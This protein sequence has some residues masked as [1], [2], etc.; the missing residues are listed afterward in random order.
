MSPRVVV[1]DAPE[2]MAEHP[3]RLQRNQEIVNVGEPVQVPVDAVSVDPAVFPPRT[4]GRPVLVG[5][6]VDPPPAEPSCGGGAAAVPP[7]PGDPP[8]VGGGG[9]GGGFAVLLDDGGG[10]GGGGAPPL[11]VPPPPAFPPDDQVGVAQFFLPGPG[12]FGAATALRFTVL[13][14]TT[15]RG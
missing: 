13:R 12:L 3:P 15:L 14:T 7:L 11:S 4:L 9:G 2:P 6:D 5:P 8:G 1:Y 10:G